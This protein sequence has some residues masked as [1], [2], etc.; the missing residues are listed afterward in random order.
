ML[1]LFLTVSPARALDSEIMPLADQ[2]LL[3]DGQVIGDRMI[4]VGE[5]GHVLVSEDQGRTWEQQSVP[6]R[7]TLTSV[8]FVDPASGWAAGHDAVILS[9]RDGGR[10]WKQIY[11]NPDDHRPILDLWFHD[12]KHGY[13]VGAYGLFLYT[14]NGGNTWKELDFSPATFTLGAADPWAE[15]QEET[16]GIDYHFNQVAVSATDR[17]Y[18]A[19]EA[20]HLYRS[21]DGAR[22]WLSLPSPYEGSFYGTLPLDHTTLL[23]YGLR[24]HL[25][26][27]EDAGITWQAIPTGVLSTFNDAIRLRDGRIVLAGLAGVLMVSD[28]GGRSFAPYSQPDRLAVAKILE[29][30]D[31]HLLLI[32]EQG[33]RRVPLPNKKAEDAP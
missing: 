26:R 22:T 21:D 3:L 2:S 5:R 14:T 19:A 20:G 32:G 24:G 9:T 23:L 13:A 16:W 7:A 17:M 1:C 6:T 8:Y 18:L 11:A 31:G 15:D 10:H 30:T 25:F 33:I 28:D 27:S 12:L 29:T 4:V